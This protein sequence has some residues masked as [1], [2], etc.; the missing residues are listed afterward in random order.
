MQG[1]KTVLAVASVGALVI[2]GTHGGLHAAPAA[3]SALAALG[4]AARLTRICS[5][6]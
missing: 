1:A 4:R 5:I 2:M 3:E 6:S